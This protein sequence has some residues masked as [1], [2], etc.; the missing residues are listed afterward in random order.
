[1]KNNLQ[2]KGFE[3]LDE[4]RFWLAVLR[5]FDKFSEPQRKKIDKAYHLIDEIYKSSKPKPEPEKIYTVEEL[6]TH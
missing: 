3:R 5:K 4:V 1:M 2:K 6:G